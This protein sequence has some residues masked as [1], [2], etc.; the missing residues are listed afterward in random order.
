MPREQWQR[1]VSGIF[2]VKFVDGC[3]GLISFDI[4]GASERGDGPLAMASLLNPKPG[5][6]NLASLY[7]QQ[8]GFSREQNKKQWGW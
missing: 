7:M 4:D 2:F 3:H 6:R 8:A 5:S 1:V